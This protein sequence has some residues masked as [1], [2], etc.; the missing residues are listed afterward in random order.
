MTQ[1]LERG[2]LKGWGQAQPL[3]PVDQVVGQQEQMEIGFVGEEVASG[4]TAQGVLPFELLDQQ[5][6]SGTVV[7][8]APQ[9]E[10]LQRQICNQNLVVIRPEFEA[11][12]LLGRLLRLG[13]PD[14]DEPIG[15][16]PPSRLV[17]EL[18][19]LDPAAGTDVPEVRE[20]ALDR[21]RQASDDHEASPPGLEPLD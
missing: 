18:G 13:P 12:Q 10:R 5:L 6:D 9:V 16:R 11:G 20:F 19:Y 4:N 8:E 1:G 2:V 15:M 3:E 14:H 21:G 17:A 7:V